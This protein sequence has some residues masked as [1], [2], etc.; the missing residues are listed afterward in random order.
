MITIMWTKDRTGLQYRVIPRGS[1]V[2]EQAVRGVAFTTLDVDTPVFMTYLMDRLHEAGVS[3]IRGC[4]L[5]INQLIE[6]GVYPFTGEGRPKTP[7]AIVCCPGLGART[8]GGVEDR[9]IYPVRGQT[10]LLRTPWVQFGM[11][12]SSNKGEGF[13][14]YIIP[15]RSGDVRWLLLRLDSW[16]IF[17][18]T[19]LM[20]GY[21]WGDQGCQ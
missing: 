7:D 19:S 11:G 20:I 3:I 8:L 18:L 1:I 16:R 10:V 2:Q 13:W 15:R 9:D 12:K 5:H 4:V 14:T 21:H 17:N 6:G